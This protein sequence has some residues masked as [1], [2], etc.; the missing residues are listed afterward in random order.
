MSLAIKKSNKLEGKIPNIILEN[1]TFLARGH[2]FLDLIG[3][4]FKI[5]YVK[6]EYFSVITPCE[7]SFNKVWF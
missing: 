2:F 1:Q 5:Y 3:S 6:F 7:Q 4:S